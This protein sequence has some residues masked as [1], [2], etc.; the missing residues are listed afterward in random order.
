[1]N[2]PIQLR[3]VSALRTCR[4]VAARKNNYRAGGYNLRQ[5]GA[6][7]ARKLK[8]CEYAQIFTFFVD[9]PRMLIVIV[10]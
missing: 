7:Q 9:M 1:M 6:I 8:F 3:K 5:I 10:P 4:S 2:G